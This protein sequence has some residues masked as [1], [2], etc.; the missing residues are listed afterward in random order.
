[1]DTA[2]FFGC[3]AAACADGRMKEGK[4]KY[5]KEQLDFAAGEKGKRSFL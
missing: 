2:A 3:G 4:M 1:M 5:T